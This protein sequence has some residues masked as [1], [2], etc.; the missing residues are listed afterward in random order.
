MNI[1]RSQLATLKEIPV[2][3]KTTENKKW[4]VIMYA[5]PKYVAEVRYN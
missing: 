3:T 1:I 4:Q 5:Q 2:P